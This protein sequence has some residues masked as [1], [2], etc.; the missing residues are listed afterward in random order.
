MMKPLVTALVALL[1]AGQQPSTPQSQSAPPPS[2]DV[3]LAGLSVS[4]GTL[5]VGKPENISR[6]PGYDNQPSFAPDG[7]SIFFTSAR[8]PGADAAQMDI[9]RYEVQSGQISRVTKTTESEYSATVTPDGKHISVIRVEQDGTQRLWKFQLDGQNPSLVFENIKPVGYHA[10][11]DANRV[12][13]F[14]LGKPATLQL[15]DV[16]SGTAEILAENIGR[17]LLRIPNGGVSFVKQ[18]GQGA[19]RRLMI[20]EL[21]LE[22]G[23]PL[24]RPLRAAVA[25]AREADLAWTPDGTLLMAHAGSLYG[26]KKGEAEWRVVADL[27]ALGL[28]DVTRLAVSPQGERIALVAAQ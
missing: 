5:T 6:S 21:V 26:W 28:K 23:K 16:R 9:F 4:G 20:S 27:G 25:G 2:T 18:E 1:A 15:G 8:E 24:V 22:G 3:Y 17:S 10:W 7:R 11:L 14:V 12:A 19:E 13:M